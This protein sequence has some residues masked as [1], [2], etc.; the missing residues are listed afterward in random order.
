MH[1]VL[2]PIEHY[3]WFEGVSPTGKHQEGL[4]QTR[5]GNSEP[6]SNGTDNNEH[7][8]SPTVSQ[9]RETGPNSQNEEP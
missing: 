2:H 5:S 9:T 3:T 4:C 7:S 1:D 6:S 8:N